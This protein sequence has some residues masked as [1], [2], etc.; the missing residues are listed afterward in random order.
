[1]MLDLMQA[2]V[3]SGTGKAA[4]LNGVPVGGKTGTTQENRDAWF[5][6]FTPDMA[7][8]VWV[9]N[10]DNAPMNGVTGG[11]T[12]ARIWHEFMDQAIKRGAKQTVAVARTQPEQQRTAP[13]SETLRGRADVIDTATLALNDRQI[14]L[15]GVEPNRDPR[16][17]RALAH[18]LR[19]R[20]VACTAA[21]DSGSY[22]CGAGGQDIAEAVLAA[23]AA[24]ASVNASPELLEIEEMARAQRVG[25]WG[26]GR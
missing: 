1:M 3:E 21:V 9:G 19:R 7:V 17:V 14:P 5:I 22:R 11:E 24:R 25:I 23:G 26:R 16:A 12:P 15:F 10:D 8:G 6:G 18:F 13:Q 20:D 2:V 4:R